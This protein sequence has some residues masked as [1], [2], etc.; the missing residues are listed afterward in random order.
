MTLDAFYL[1]SGRACALHVNR[2]GFCS[3]KFAWTSQHSFHIREVGIGHSSAWVTA[4]TLDHNV[5]E[6]MAHGGPWPH[7][8]CDLF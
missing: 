2:P 3:Q 5:L 4:R 1:L 8:G 7:S 6:D